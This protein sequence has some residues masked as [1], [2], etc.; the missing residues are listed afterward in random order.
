V[1]DEATQ[2]DVWLWGLKTPVPRHRVD[3]FFDE[4][5]SLFGYDVTE[6]VA[7]GDTL[8]TVLYWRPLARFERYYNVFVHVEVEGERIYGQSDEAPACGAESTKEWEPGEVTVDGH[9]LRID[10]STPPGEYP[11]LAGLYDPMTGERV[12]VSGRDANAWGNA[13]YLGTV[14]VDDGDASQEDTG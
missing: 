4:K 7:A 8:S 12:P 2:P 14:E 9:T 13:V 5:V 11:I 3:A 10:P 1:F 6:R